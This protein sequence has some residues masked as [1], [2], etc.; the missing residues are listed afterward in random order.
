M[1][2]PDHIPPV[3]YKYRDWSDTY[4]K[5]LLTHGEVYFASADQFNDPFDCAIP[6]RYKPEELTPENVFLATVKVLRQK[7]P[8]NSDAE[9][10]KIAYKGQQ[11]DGIHDP[12]NADKFNKEYHERFNK[13]WGI[14]SLT[15]EDNN[16][17]MWSHYSCSHS[18]F[19]I[20]LGTELLY[21]QTGG[22]LET[23]SYNS[24]FPE[25]SLFDELLES[26]RKQTFIKSE[27]W[28]YEREHRLLKNGYS[29]KVVKL[30]PDTIREIIFGVKMDQNTKFELLGLIKSKYPNAKV[31]ECKLHDSKFELVK[32]QIR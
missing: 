32:T 10:H 26:F 28:E 11:K 13:G 23:V 30:N 5:R 24:I 6:R 9:L 27:V 4:Q 14:L 17:L 21:Q 19:C 7:Y 16:F 15:A 1:A 3:L 31:Y 25:F 12:D 20:G 18:G 2:F 29:R 22:Q 8:K